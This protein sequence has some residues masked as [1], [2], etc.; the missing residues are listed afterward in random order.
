MNM[1]GM[2]PGMEMRQDVDYN[3]M[4]EAAGTLL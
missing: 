2:P 3:Q 1:M 4:M